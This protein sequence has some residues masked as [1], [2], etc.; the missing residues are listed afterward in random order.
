MSPLFW[1]VV[2]SNW[3]RPLLLVRTS[4]ILFVAG[5]EDEISVTGLFITDLFKIPWSYP[6]LYWS[7]E[8]TM[9]FWDLKIFSKTFKLWRVPLISFLPVDVYKWFGRVKLP[10]MRTLT[11][12]IWFSIFDCFT[13]FS[14]FYDEILLTILSLAMSF[15]LITSRIASLVM[16]ASCFFIVDRRILDLR[17]TISWCLNLS[18]LTNENESSILVNLFDHILCRT[19]VSSTYFICWGIMSSTF[20]I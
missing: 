3:P 10:S 19:N 15:C 9:S 11:I 1:L 13:I 16:L 18:L 8:Y 14:I 20:S 6:K 12:S 5:L 17:S 2:F 7:A 4:Y